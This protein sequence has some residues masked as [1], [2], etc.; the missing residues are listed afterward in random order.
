MKNVFHSL[1]NNR[2]Y[3]ITIIVLIIVMF[4]L[5]PILKIIVVDV[6]CSFF[7]GTV[8]GRVVMENGDT[9]PRK[10]E[11]IEISWSTDN[12]F[13]TCKPV[14]TDSQ[15]EY[16]FEREVPVGGYV[17][18]YAKYETGNPVYTRTVYEGLDGISGVRWFLGIP[19]SSGIP[20]R[21]DFVIPYRPS[22]TIKNE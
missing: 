21:V 19:F 2:W 4:I 20:M 1:F 14:L 11:N 9:D 3:P 16:I 15:G 8:Y 18:M 12:I 5:I 6:W 13:T 7:K 10:L 22:Q 17:S